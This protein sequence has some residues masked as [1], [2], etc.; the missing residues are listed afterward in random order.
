MPFS[1]AMRRIQRSER[2]LIA[3]GF[4]TV[5]GAASTAG[6]FLRGRFDFLLLRARLRLA[7]FQVFTQCGSEPFIAILV[8]QRF[9]RASHS[10]ENT[11]LIDVLRT[12]HE[13]L[14]GL[15]G[16]PYAPRFFTRP[17]GLVVQYIDAGPPTAPRT[18]LRLHRPP[19]WS[20]LYRRMIPAFVAAGH[21]VIAPD[22]L[23]FGG[24]DKPRKDA[25]Y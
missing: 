5:G 8:R 20:Y 2:M 13:R 6:L 16:W 4:L 15:H 22:F 10:R 11:P 21:R 1:C 17:D 18:W 14:A 23:G 19:T 12:S 9:G 3:S 24:S 25:V 7:P